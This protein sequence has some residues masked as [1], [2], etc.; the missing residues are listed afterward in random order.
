MKR[1]GNLYALATSEDALYQ[2]YLDA[3]RGKRAR[4]A[5]HQFERALGTNLETLRRTLAD[6]SY[7][8]EPYRSFMVYEPKPR[9]ISAPSFR[10]RVVQHAIYGVVRP[11]FDR[12][13]IDQ[14]FACRPGLGTHAAADYVQ[15]ALAHSAPCSY[16]VHLDVRRFYYS[17]DRAVLQ[18]LLARKIKDQR[19]LTLMM[20]FTEMPD[21]VGLPIGNL[22]SQLFALVYLNPVDHFIKRELQVRRYCRYVDDLVLLDL[23]RPDAFAA[24]AEIERFLR[25]EL[26]LQLSKATIAPTSRGVNFAGYRTWATRRFVRRHALANFRKA[27]RR[28]DAQAVMSSLG[29]ARKS[30]SH[31][32]LINHLKEHWHAL[33]TCLPPGHRRVDHAPAAV[34]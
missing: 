20:R 5:C 16:T 34:A 10:D 7:Q 12:T 9:L 32:H 19:L 11:I 8:P 17:I 33:S 15:H 18:Q 24:K 23:P 6:G 30:A 1:H 21:P 25:H 2:A 27:V 4:H 31:S 28:G 29:H 13:F 26:H 3:R 22:L 14:S